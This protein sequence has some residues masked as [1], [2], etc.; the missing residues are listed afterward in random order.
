VAYFLNLMQQFKT[1][2]II[3]SY[4]G[5]DYAGWQVQKDKKTIA[6]TLQDSFLDVFGRPITVIG[7]SRTDAGVH[8][9][10]QVATFKTDLA[11]DPQTLQWA[12]GNHIPDNITIRSLEL[13]PN[14]FNPHLHIVQKT[15][16]YHF[17]T[18]TPLPFFARYG[19]H[20]KKRVDFEKLQQALDVFVGTHDFRSFATGN[21]RENT[22]RTIDA[23]AVKEL[24]KYTAHA[25]VIKG[26]KFLRHMIRRLV[27][28]ALVVA[29]SPAWSIDDL[30]KIL[31]QKNPDHTL[32]NAPA[33]G[34]VLYK[35]RYKKDAH[36]SPG[37]V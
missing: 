24:K 15:Y 20:I 4:E 12:W 28:A 8:A 25:I 30:K 27:G 16:M 18:Q 10:G 26:P 21:E 1:Y 22:V 9:L 7:V 5:T 32:L 2:K 37:D 14:T 13:V 3:I 19:W 36:A 17:F 35:I 6:Q 34:L 33:K 31:A 23:I 11:I 29:T